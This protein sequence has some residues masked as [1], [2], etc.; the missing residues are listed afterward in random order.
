MKEYRRLKTIGRSFGI[1]SEL[2]NPEETKSKFLFINDKIIQGSLFISGCGV[3]DSKALCQ[4][5]IQAAMK[6]GARVSFLNSYTIVY[7]LLLY[8]T[9]R[10][11]VVRHI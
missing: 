8:P 7:N 4:G 5:Y 9:G 3:V 6:K 1:E 11:V 2:L 10:E